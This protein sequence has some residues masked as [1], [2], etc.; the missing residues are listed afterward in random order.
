MP[1]ATASDAARSSCTSRRDS[2]PETQREPGTAT[3]PSSVT[4][5]LYV[6]NG[7]PSDF[8][9]APR[10]VLPARGEAVEQ[11]DVDAGGDEPLDAA[12]VDDRVRVER[13]DDD[14]CDTRLDDRV[15]ARRRPPVVRARLE[16][17]VER[18]A[19]GPVARLL[20]RDRLGVLHAR[21]LV[22]ALADGLAVAD[23]HR[24][25]ERM[26]LDLAASALGELER[27]LEPVPRARECAAFR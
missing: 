17:D 27:A 14:A 15:R 24:A 2:S 20:E 23:E 10:L 16:R 7:R 5:T 26:I 12:S 22:P 19:A 13:A 21:E 25:D 18:R 1:T 9:V 6:T 11:L 4:A 8:H 3:R